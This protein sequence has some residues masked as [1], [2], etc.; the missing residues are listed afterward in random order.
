MNADVHHEVLD[1]WGLL[2]LQGP[3]AAEYLQ[4]LTSFDLKALTF[5]KSAFVPIEG[6]NLH[7]ARG[8]YTG[9]DGFEVRS[10]LTLPRFS[11]NLFLIL[12]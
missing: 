4:A 3:L 7:V 1:G 2:A 6:Y 8:G 5:G 10:L 12:F 11:F 9:E